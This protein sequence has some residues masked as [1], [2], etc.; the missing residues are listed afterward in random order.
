MPRLAAHDGMVGIVRPIGSADRAPVG[1]YNDL[2]IVVG[3]IDVAGVHQR[4]E[5]K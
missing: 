4:L 1:L 3:V 2:Y 5:A